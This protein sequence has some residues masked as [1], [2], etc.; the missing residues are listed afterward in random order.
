ME[1]LIINLVSEQTLPNIQIIKE[2]KNENTSFLFLSTARMERQKDWI[3]QACNIVESKCRTIIVEEF[4][5]ADIQEKL[6]KFDFFPYKTLIVNITGGTKIMSIACSDFF[7]TP[8]FQDKRTSILY[9]TGR[10]NK[11][12]TLYPNPE[13]S[14]LQQK[15]SLA[16]Y[17]KAYGFQC[18][19]GKSSGI[20]PT[21]TEAFFKKFINHK[22]EE[23]QDKWDFLRLK[24]GKKIDEPEF[25]KYNLSSLLVQLAFFPEKPNR[26]S[27][28]ET[29][30]LTGEWF[31]EYIGYRIKKELQLN[32]DDLFIGSELIKD[33]PSI[34][35]AN[36]IDTLLGIEPDINS[37]K[38]EFDV[39]FIYKNTFYTVE[40]KSSI[41]T[42]N[43]GNGKTQNILGETIYKAD[44]LKT[45]FGL[46]AKTAIVTLTDFKEYC[47]A[48]E[49]G[50][51]N[52][53]INE[54]RDLINRAN[55]SNIKLIDKKAIISN[56]SISDLIIR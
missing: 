21:K 56:E 52:N 42:S 25:N 11:Y 7:K 37:T 18:K 46:Y 16:E 13:T 49:L 19:Q 5:Y 1:S 34:K 53:R 6:A 45:R 14:Q 38:N 48:T 28:S 41:V 54:M 47:N 36:S 23:Y 40:C 44:S 10:N 32:D 15:I 24:R 51:K 12:L 8:R 9:L 22:T 3:C 30:Y 55:L 26:L 39:M 50:T 33:S 27:K 17:L 31:E 29:K 35:H 4:S 43:K 2:F 20:I